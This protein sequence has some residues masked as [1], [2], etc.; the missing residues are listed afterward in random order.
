MAGTICTGP[1]ECPM[2]R[3][4]AHAMGARDHLSAVSAAP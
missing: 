2:M 3:R 1:T 4:V